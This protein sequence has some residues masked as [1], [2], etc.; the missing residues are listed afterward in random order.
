MELRRGSLLNAGPLLFRGRHGQRRKVGGGCAF[1]V[2]IRETKSKQ[3]L[4][5]R[6]DCRYK[7]RVL[8]ED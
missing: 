2:A 5:V 8:V 1:P 6:C 3:V 7:Q 4:F